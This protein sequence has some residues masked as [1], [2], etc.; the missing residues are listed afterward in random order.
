M[1]ED[2]KGNIKAIFSVIRETPQAA[3]HTVYFPALQEVCRAFGV[4]SDEVTKAYARFERVRG[5]NPVLIKKAWEAYHL[6]LDAL[7]IVLETNYFQLET[8][9]KALEEKKK[10]EA[11]CEKSISCQESPAAGNPPT[12]PA[13]PAMDC[14]APATQ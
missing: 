11:E 14:T 6:Q 7:E 9:M 8:V 1:H 4:K 10:E 5:K 13:A 12:Q 2:V 3:G